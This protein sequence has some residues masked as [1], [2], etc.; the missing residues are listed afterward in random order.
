MSAA[1]IE[2]IE[3]ATGPCRALNADILRHLGW[4]ER[5]GEAFG[6]DGERW[7]LS[8]PD[9]TAS[10]DDAM[11][12]LPEGLGHGCFF[13]QRSRS[14][15]CIAD[16]WIDTEFNRY[17]KGKAATPVLALCS[18]ALQARAALAKALPVTSREMDRD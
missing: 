1:L 17:R 16:V 9:Y 14:F 4:T 8:I 12:L 3:A 2:R 11:T 13:L 5:D 18:A 7:R 6:P 15:G 10:L